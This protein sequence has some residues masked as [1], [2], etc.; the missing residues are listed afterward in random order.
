[1]SYFSQF[2]I[3]VKMDQNGLIKSC[4][5]LHIWKIKYEIFMKL[6]IFWD[7]LYFKKQIQYFKKKRKE[8]REKTIKKKIHNQTPKWIDKI[9]NSSLT[10]ALFWPTHCNRNRS[11]DIFFWKCTSFENVRHTQLYTHTISDI[12]ATSIRG[13]TYY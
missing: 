9:I 6:N 12:H 2:L 4:Y 11:S 8:K 13:Y 5:G 7:W 3:D 10:L 1:M